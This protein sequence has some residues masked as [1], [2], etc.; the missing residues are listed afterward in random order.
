[1][2]YLL[3]LTF[4]LMSLSLYSQSFWDDVFD[5]PITINRD[6]LCWEME[7]RF[8]KTLNNWRLKNGLNELEYD[9]DMQSLLT[10]PWNERQV[11]TGMAGH[12]DG[13]E[14][15]KNRSN[16]VGIF[17][18]GE[19]CGINH[20]SDVGDK[21]EIFLLY[22]GSPSHWKI[23]TNP[24]FKYVSVSVMYDQETSRYYSV[25]NLR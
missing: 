15:F 10:V 17:G 4:T 14:S 21:S 11:Q 6:S 25:V 18:G 23:L 19:C 13:N 24:R 22:K 7:K 20:I 16:G 1:M 3:T 5:S 8:V 2:K 12:G 9:Y